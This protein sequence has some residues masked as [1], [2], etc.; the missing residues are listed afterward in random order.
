MTDTKSE[1]EKIVS[2]TP[3]SK[4]PRL[5]GGAPDKS[6]NA[7]EQGM[8]NEQRQGQEQ[9]QEPPTNNPSSSREDR[10]D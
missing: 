2:K 8:G 5:P 7:V 3:T 10:G 1:P 9:L 6:K 4:D